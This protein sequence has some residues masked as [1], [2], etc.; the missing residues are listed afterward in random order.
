MRARDKRTA[1]EKNQVLMFYLLEENSEKPQGVASKTP[2]PQY[3]RGLN[4]TP[5]VSLLTL[6]MTSPQVYE[7][8]VCIN[9]YPTDG[10]TLKTIISQLLVKEFTDKNRLR[11][12]PHFSSGIVERVK[13]ER[14]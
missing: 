11:V 10:H 8:S 14:A 2:P 9:H 7:T 5:P 13:R 3:V 12:V 4:D 6:K 1:I